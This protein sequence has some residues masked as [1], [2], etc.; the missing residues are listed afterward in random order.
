VNRLPV[1]VV[2]LLLL[3]ASRVPGGQVTVRVPHRE[4]GVIASQTQEAAREA[5]LS[6]S[7]AIVVEEAMK[8][9]G[10]A[11][12][13]PPAEHALF[14]NAMQKLGAEMI[15]LDA[16]VNRLGTTVS[17]TNESLDLLDLG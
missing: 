9:D 16:N 8:Q 12:S 17:G 3:T 14:T 7:E 6:A 15:K 11:A 4:A 1:A 13:L 10:G 5:G 2:S